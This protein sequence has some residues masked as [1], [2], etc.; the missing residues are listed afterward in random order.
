MFGN[1]IYTAYNLFIDKFTQ[2]DECFIKY[3]NNIEII[4]FL[5]FKNKFFID[6]S[7]FNDIDKNI[8]LNLMH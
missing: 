8:N 2:F 1:D 5:K 6:K 4:S 7:E 3:I